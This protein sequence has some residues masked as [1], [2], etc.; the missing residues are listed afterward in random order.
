MAR[1]KQIQPLSNKDLA[2]THTA[3]HNP[4]QA[5][6]WDAMTAEDA[7]M[8]R[9]AIW[10]AQLIRDEGIDAGDAY[11]RGVADA[12]HALQRRALIH[13]VRD[14]VSPPEQKLE[15]DPTA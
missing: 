3:E 7:P 4:S 2:D 14:K 8:V 6:K 12:H 13:E 1:K 5:Q 9:K 10:Q 11:L 15:V